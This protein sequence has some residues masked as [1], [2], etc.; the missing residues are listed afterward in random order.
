[1]LRLF[2]VI[3]SN[4]SKIGSVLNMQEEQVECGVDVVVEQE[5]SL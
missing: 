2:Y 1:M 5:E 3:R 4:L